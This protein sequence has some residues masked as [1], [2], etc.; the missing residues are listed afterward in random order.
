[1][2]RP[3]EIRQILPSPICNA[4]HLN[5]VTTRVGGML[6]AVKNAV[7]GLLWM[8]PH[9]KNLSIKSSFTFRDKFV[10]KVLHVFHF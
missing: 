2:I 9:A 5:L 6:V 8:S 4:K 7:D 3:E 10:L 1:M